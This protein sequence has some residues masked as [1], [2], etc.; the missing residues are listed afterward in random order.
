MSNGTILALD[1]SLCNTGFAVYGKCTGS[2]VPEV[3]RV[4]LIQRKQD[5]ACK[6]AVFADILTTGYYLLHKYEPRQVVIESP[7]VCRSEGAAASKFSVYMLAAFFAV[8]TFAYAAFSTMAL[9]LPSDLFPSRSVASVSGMSGTGAGI[10]TIISTWLIGYA[11]DHYSFDP[12]LI[13]ASTIPLVAT[14]LVL[15]LLRQ[16]QTAPNRSAQRT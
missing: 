4:G 11:A 5:K 9:V 15:W 3:A 7:N 1:H 14:G 13:A 6:H 8:S 12:V 2:A 16:P 10:G